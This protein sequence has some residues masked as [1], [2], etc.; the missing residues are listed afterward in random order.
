MENRLGGGGKGRP[1][2]EVRASEAGQGVAVRVY[3]CSPHSALQMSFTI[4]RM[5]RVSASPTL[6]APLWH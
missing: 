2:S 1:V 4:N 6:L 5:T 3:L